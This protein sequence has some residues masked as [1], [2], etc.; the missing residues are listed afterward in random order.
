MKSSRCR[1][2]DLEVAGG[3]VV[4]QG[5]HGASLAEQGPVGLELTAVAD[6][7]TSDNANQGLKIV[8]ISYLGQLC[9]QL[10][11]PCLGE[12]GQLVD[13]AVVGDH[14]EVLLVPRDVGYGE[15]DGREDLLIDNISHIPFEH[16]SKH[17]C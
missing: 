16:N 13:H 4:D 2:V 5:R 15:A 17:T 7:L 6:G 8:F 11:I 14:G 1:P 10:V 9:P 3:Q 12:L